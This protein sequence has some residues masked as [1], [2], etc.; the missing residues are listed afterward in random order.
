MVDTKEMYKTKPNS[1][2]KP[3]FRPRRKVKPLW[4]LFEKKMSM[5]HGSET[6]TDVSNTDG[7]IIPHAHDRYGMV[8]ILINVVYFIIYYLEKL[9][10]LIGF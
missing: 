5:I 6:E 2:M 9:P 3:F 7:L 4:K 10:F 8:R 1:K